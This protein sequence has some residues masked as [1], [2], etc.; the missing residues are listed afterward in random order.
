MPLKYTGRSDTITVLGKTYA[1]PEL[2]KR[3][4]NAYDGPFDKAIPGLTQEMAIHLMNQSR[5]HTFETTQGEDLAEK[6]TAPTAKSG[7]DGLGGNS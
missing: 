5:M 6:V 7:S 1:R 4:P 2:Y 3:N